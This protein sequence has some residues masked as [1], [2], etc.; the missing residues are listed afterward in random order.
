MC[1]HVSR[2]EKGKKLYILTYLSDSS[3]QYKL[4]LFSDIG[5]EQTTNAA[6]G[7]LGQ[8]IINISLKV[9]NK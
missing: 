7:F 1:T 2:K 4:G 5:N 8:E 9:I 3:I 6:A